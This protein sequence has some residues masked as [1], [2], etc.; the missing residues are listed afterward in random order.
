MRYRASVVM[1]RAARL[2]AQSDLPVED[3][4][5]QVGYGSAQSFSRAF[6]RQ[7]GL[8]PREYRRLHAVA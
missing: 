2:L 4:A 8:S 1:Q 3:I 5:Y 6:R 7:Y